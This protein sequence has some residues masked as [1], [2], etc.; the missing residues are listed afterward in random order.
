MRAIRTRADETFQSRSLAESRE[1]GAL[2]TAERRMFFHPPSELIEHG[3]GF[4]LKIAAPG[5]QADQIPVAV[6]PDCITV[7]GKVRTFGEPEQVIFSGLRNRELFRRFPLAQAIVLIDQGED[8]HV[9]FQTKA[10]A[11]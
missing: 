7:R 1:T 6:E 3:P 10:A 4:R 8:S 9:Q 5:F 11:G 2:D